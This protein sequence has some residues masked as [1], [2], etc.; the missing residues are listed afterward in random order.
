MGTPVVRIRR[1]KGACKSAATVHSIAFRTGPKRVLNFLKPGKTKGAAAVQVL[2]NCLPTSRNAT[3]VT[4]CS[5]RASSV[6]IHRQVNC[7]P[8]SPPLCPRVAMRDFLG[9][10][11]G[12]GNIPTKVHR[13]QTAVTVRHYNLVSQ[14]GIVVHGLS[15]NC[16]RQINVTRTVVRSPPIVVLSRPAIN[17]S[18]HRV[19]RIHRLVGDLTNDHAVVLSARVLPRIDVAYS[20]IAVVGHNR[21]ITAS[22][23]SGLATHLTKR[24]ACSMRVGNGIRRTRPLLTGLASIH[25]I[26]I[27]KRRRLPSRRCHLQVAKRD[28]CD[29]NDTVTT[30][31]IGTNLRLRRLHHRRTALRSIFLGLAAARPTTPDAPRTPTSP[32]PIVPRPAPRAPPLWISYPPFALPPFALPPP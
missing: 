11:N 24:A 21:I 22:A 1:L 12:V 7:L 29:L 19:G 18:P 10:I 25:R 16:Q 17:L 28:G 20:H 4:K 32:R 3:Q 26:I 14:H 2:S 30:A 31:L 13:R 15:G 27:L 23:P 9:F 6:T 8:R 5:I